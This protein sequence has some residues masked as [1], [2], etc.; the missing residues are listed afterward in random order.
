MSVDLFVPSENDAKHFSYYFQDYLVPSLDTSPQ[1]SIAFESTSG[2]FNRAK[3]GVKRKLHIKQGADSWVLYDEYESAPSLPTPFPPFALTPLKDKMRS[4]HA[5]AATIPGSP[6]KALLLHG[7]SR[8]GK[9]TLLLELLKQGWSF[10]CD[11]T[12]LAGEEGELYSYSRPIGV[13][14]RTLRVHPWISQY[15]TSAPSFLT[16]TGTTWAVHP[17]SLPVLRGPSCTK[18][19]GTVHL[20]F[21]SE[22]SIRRLS[23]HSWSISMDPAKHT[24]RAA[25]SLEQETLGV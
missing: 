1:L 11:D 10:I 22:F 9:S 24:A 14:E 21:A 2:E 23:E 15:L 3:E 20:S 16:S 13:R 12:A 8:S 4:F 18:W 17:N 19:F 25:D 6:D 5:S 7:P